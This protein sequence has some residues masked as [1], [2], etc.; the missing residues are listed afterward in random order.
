[1]AKIRYNISVILSEAEESLKQCGIINSMKK[2]VFSIIAT[3]LVLIVYFLIVSKFFS[4]MT[5]RGLFGDMFGG[6]NALFSGLAFLGVIYA[7]VLQR[8]EL[9][10]QRSELEMTRRELKKS[11]EAQE[12]SEKALSKTAKLNARAAILNYEGSLA[13][14]KSNKKEDKKNSETYSTI[15]GGIGAILDDPKSL[16]AQGMISEIQTILEEEN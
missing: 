2:I 8:E 3:L 16:T 6:I 7:I 5:D 10:L 9:K 12:K 14:A 13:I 11:A 1:M 4:K 15:Y